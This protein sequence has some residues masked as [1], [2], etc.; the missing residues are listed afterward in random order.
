MAG[1]L[2][3]PR[4]EAKPLFPGYESIRQALLRG[5][6]ADVKSSAASLAKAAREAA[7]PE[8]VR[9]AEAIAESGDIESARRAF[10]ALSDSMIAYRKA[11]KEAPKPQVAYCAMVKQSW[12]QPEGEIGNPYYA[13]TA[14]RTCGDVKRD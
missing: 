13:D 8:V 2:F 4:A 6:I 10:A 14:M 12:L 7:H 5:S 9:A 1:Y 11:S 3:V